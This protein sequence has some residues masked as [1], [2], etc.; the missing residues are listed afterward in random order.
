MDGSRTPPAGATTILVVD[1]LEAVRRLARR[2]LQ[3]AGYR[4]LEAGDGVE[5]LACLEQSP[6]VDLVL[7]DLRMPKMDGWE[8]ATHLARRSPPLPVLFMSGY[9]EHLG[10]ESIA[11]PVLAKPFIPAQLCE[12]VRHLVG[13]EPSARSR[14]TL[15]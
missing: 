9:D 1:D 8:L 15:V 10:S 7:T 4:V 13:N 12:Q 5:A 11:G 14:A 2:A 3:D 6:V